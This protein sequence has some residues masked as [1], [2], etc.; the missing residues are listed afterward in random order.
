[1]MLLIWAN[2][3]CFKVKKDKKTWLEEMEE[4]YKDDK[5]PQ[6]RMK[7]TGEKIKELK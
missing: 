5:L 4:K 1:M 7:F 2:Q 3:I 6:T